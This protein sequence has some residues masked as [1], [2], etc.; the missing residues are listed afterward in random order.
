MVD[1]SLGPLELPVL[2]LNVASEVPERARLIF[3]VAKRAREA[4]R[5]IIL[6]VPVQL[7]LVREQLLADCTQV[8]LT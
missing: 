1:K 3:V 4:F 2:A 6:V 7:V 8:L 5:L